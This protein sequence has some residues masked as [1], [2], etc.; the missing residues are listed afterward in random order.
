MK[1]RGLEAKYVESKYSRAI[2][3]RIRVCRSR[4]DLGKDRNGGKVRKKGLHAVEM[5]MDVAGWEKTS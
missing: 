1:A 3:L 5:M 4:S 2:F